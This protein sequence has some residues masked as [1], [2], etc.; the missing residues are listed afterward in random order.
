MPCTRFMLDRNKVCAYTRHYFK[1]YEIYFLHNQ[2]INIYDYFFFFLSCLHHWHSYRITYY[3]NT[4]LEL[5]ISLNCCFMLFTNFSWLFVHCYGDISPFFSHPLFRS[6]MECLDLTWPAQL[7][8][9]PH[10]KTSSLCSCTVCSRLLTPPLLPS[11]LSSLVTP[12]QILWIL[13]VSSPSSFFVHSFLTVLFVFFPSV[14]F[15]P[16]HYQCFFREYIFSSKKRA[17]KKIDSSSLS[18]RNKS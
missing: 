18:L 1:L 8:T 7:Y 13:F 12:H 3:I 14:F 17:K 16:S 10:G 15:F 2:N 6:L 4:L 5:S 11:P 9:L